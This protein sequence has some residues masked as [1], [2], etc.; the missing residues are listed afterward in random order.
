MQSAIKTAVGYFVTQLSKA[1]IAAWWIVKIIVGVQRDM[2]ILAKNVAHHGES[3]ATRCGMSGRKFRVIWC[4][5]IRGPTRI[6]ISTD[7]SNRTD[8]VELVFI[9]EEYCACIKYR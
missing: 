8:Q 1:G 7:I 3:S 4:G 9:G 2:E 5:N 6:N